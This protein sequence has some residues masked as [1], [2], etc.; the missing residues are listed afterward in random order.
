MS[1]ADIDWLNR[2]PDAVVSNTFAHTNNPAEAAPASM[3]KAT[4]TIVPILFEARFVDPIARLVMLETLAE[5]LH[6]R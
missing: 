4:P 3:D 2:S 1:K 5:V 6:V